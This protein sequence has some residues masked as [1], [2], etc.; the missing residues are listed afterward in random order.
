MSTQNPQLLSGLKAGADLRTHQYKFVK[1]NG[2]NQVILCAAATDVPLGILQND[3]NTN[4][5][6]VV[7]I[8]GTSKFWCAGALAVQVKV[9]TDANAKGTTAASTHHP[10]G[11]TIQASGGADEFPV[12]A[13]K[14]SLVPLA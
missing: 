11:I 10:F 12:L 1:I 2:D 9:A 8:G 3:P 4:E 6:A 7:A 14:P 13:I 5:E